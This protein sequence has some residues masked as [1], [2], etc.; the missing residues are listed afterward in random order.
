MSQTLTT[1][2]V[3][4]EME[5]V[6]FTVRHNLITNDFEV[7]GLE[8]YGEDAGAILPIKLYE[9]LADSYENS[10]KATIMDYL[11]VIARD[12]SYNPVLELITAKKWDGKDHISTIYKALHIPEVDTLSRT[13][14]RKWFMQGI[15]LLHNDY[16]DPF[17]ADGCLVLIGKQGAGKTS[18]FRKAAMSG[19]ELKGKYFRDGQELDDRDKDKKRRVVTTWIAELGE[20]GSTLKSDVDSLKAFITSEYDEYRLPYG[21]TDKKAPRRTN[22]CGTANDSD[23]EIG[24]LIDPTGNRRFWTVPVANI[25]LEAVNA[26]DFL[27]VWRQAYH[28]VKTEGLQA[29]RLT[30]EEQAAV[31]IRN[32]GHMKQ[33]KGMRE[34][35]DILYEAIENPHRFVWEYQTVTK[36]KMQY[37]ALK[38]IDSTILGRAITLAVKNNPSYNAGEHFKEKRERHDGKPTRV[39]CLPSRNAEPLPQGWGDKN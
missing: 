33:T 20:I 22:L 2:D 39:K 4:R 38:N 32:A 13:L 6:G 15:S 9:L 23:E 25:D 1:I 11:L 27:N 16:Q 30:K 17:G 18:F 8:K 3:K 21:R 36:W 19:K 24:Y 31:E 37:E 28:L 12:S 26:I 14:I 7:T 34:V 5:R 35:D 29:F 10:S